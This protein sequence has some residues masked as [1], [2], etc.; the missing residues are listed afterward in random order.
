M[1][2][3]GSLLFTI[4]EGITDK[5]F[6]RGLNNVINMIQQPEVYF[7]KGVRDV[8]SG[9]SVPQSLSQMKDLGEAEVMIR[10]SRT[11]VDAILRKIPIA[12]EKVPA[13]RTFLGEAVYKQNPL[14]LLGVFNPVYVSSKKN[15]SVD[16]TIMELVHGFGMPPTNFLNHRDTDMRQFYNEDGRQAYDRFLELSSEIKLGGK[17]MR[18]SL[19]GLINSRQF[20]AMTKAVEAAGGTAKLATKDPRV[21]L[22]NKVMG[23]Y[24]LKAKNQVVQEFPELL[25]T[26]NKLTKQ[27]NE[28][29]RRTVDEFNKPPIPTL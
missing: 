5:S 14:G 26:L 10:E 12:E 20:K 4:S 16:K 19:K 3:V 7:G 24:R 1:E 11:V 6:L 8:V 28:L 9:L 21:S 18:E 25:E 17:T 23:A 29:N 15:D 13:K 2:A 22:M 27:K